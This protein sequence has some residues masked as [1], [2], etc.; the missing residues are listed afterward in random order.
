MPR[1][2][3][4]S[5]PDRSKAIPF[6]RLRLRGE[7]K[8]RQRD[9]DRGRAG[10]KPARNLGLPGLNP[11]L[12]KFAMRRT[13][14]AA[15][16]FLVATFI[17][18][19]GLFQLG[20]PFEVGPNS[21]IMPAG[22]KAILEETFGRDKPLPVQYLMFLRDLFT[23]SLGIDYDERRPVID[24]LAETVPNTARLAVLAMALELLFG[25]TAGVLAA[26]RRASFWDTLVTTGAT[27]L[28]SVPILVT[29]SFLRNAL[30]GASLL[31]VTVFPSLPVI[32]GHEP[33]WLRLIG[34][35]AVTL[36]A[37]SMAFT[38]RLVRTSMLEVL[39][40]DYVRMARAKGL[41][42]RK[43]VFKHA[44]RN[45]VLPIANLATINLGALFAGALI[46]ETIYQFPGVGYLFVRSLRSLN[47]PVLIAVFAYS[48]VVFVVL[49]A[50][51]DILCAFL[52]PRL[53]ID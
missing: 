30:S 9:E 21:R 15:L 17:I 2:A 8:Q 20:D 22:T 10:E 44:L 14:Q 31:G 25:I 42:P 33:H 53:R 26:V 48:V 1:F 18:Y 24:L 13:G 7:R 43:V 3:K 37:A 35:P 11:T 28:M 39:E 4:W 27:V 50:L 47:T 41:P 49:I 52:D 34:L 46:V 29:A 38:A 23:G 16:V 5:A 12:W 40:S 36:A 6:P 19:I 32:F 45:A 51:L